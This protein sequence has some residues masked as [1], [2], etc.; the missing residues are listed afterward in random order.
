MA[1]PELCSSEFEHG[2]EVCGVFFVAR[3]E[4]PEVLDAIEEP[5]DAI[6]RSIEYRAE[7]GFPAAVHHRRDVGRGAN[8]FDLPTQPVGVVG[9][10][11]QDDRA[12]VQVPKQSLGDRAVTRLTGR[13]DEFER[14]TIGVDKGVNLGRQPTTRAAH[15][16]IRV[17]FFEF[18]A[19]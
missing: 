14:Q 19:C 17:A 8:G 16:A 5:F 7:A 11:G 6:A 3:G 1:Q 12:F 10:V 4:A 13:Q 15:T 18:A 9:F 2:E